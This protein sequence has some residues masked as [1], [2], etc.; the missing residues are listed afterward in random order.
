M[1]KVLGACVIVGAGVL[2]VYLVYTIMELLFE[3]AV[4]RVF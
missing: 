3:M 1:D 4:Q 2:Y